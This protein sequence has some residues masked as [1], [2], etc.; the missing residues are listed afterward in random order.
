MGIEVKGSTTRMALAKAVAILVE[1]VG[2]G[3]DE[4]TFV[5]SIDG[6]EDGIDFS[7]SLEDIHRRIVADCD[8]EDG[9]WIYRGRKA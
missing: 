8:Y 9:K 1:G 2:A 3:K 6:Q 7:G 5:L 4:A